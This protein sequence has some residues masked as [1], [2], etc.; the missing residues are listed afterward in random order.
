MSFWCALEQANRYS[1]KRFLIV[2]KEVKTIIDYDSMTRKEMLERM[3][4]TYTLVFSFYLHNM[5][6]KGIKKIIT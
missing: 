1:K 5:G 2:I 6:I 4:E 3:I